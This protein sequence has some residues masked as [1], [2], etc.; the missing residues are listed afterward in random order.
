MQGKGRAQVLCASVERVANRAIRLRSECRL[1]DGNWDC[2]PRSKVFQLELNGR[3]VSV[4]FPAALNSWSAYKMMQAIG[5]AAVPLALPAAR[6]PGDREDRCALAGDDDD[7]Q[8]ARM[9]LRCSLWTV[10]F[11]KLCNAADCRYEPA[12]RRGS[13]PPRRVGRPLR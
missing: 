4:D 10:E 1:A 7:P 11:V 13:D 5:P 6:R 2:Q 12:A 3:T 8:V 9:T